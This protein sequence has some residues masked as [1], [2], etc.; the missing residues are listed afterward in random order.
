MPEYTHE[1]PHHIETRPLFHGTIHSHGSPPDSDDLHV[2]YVHNHG[3]NH[4]DIDIAFDGK[5]QLTKFKVYEKG[6]Q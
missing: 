6:N 1:D 2:V 4:N 3:H 5:R